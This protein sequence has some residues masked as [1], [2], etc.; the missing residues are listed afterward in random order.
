MNS[1]TRLGSTCGLFFLLGACASP[2]DE[3]SAS[4]ADAL[5]SIAPAAPLTPSASTTGYDYVVRHLPDLWA[6]LYIGRSATDYDFCGATAYFPDRTTCENGLRAAY[7]TCV[8]APAEQDFG[9]CIGRATGAAIGPNGQSVRRM[10]DASVPRLVD[11]MFGNAA[12]GSPRYGVTYCGGNGYC[13]DQVR[14]A[15][16]RCL[17]ERRA[18]GWFRCAG[19]VRFT[20]PRFAGNTASCA[21]SAFQPGF[22]NDRGTVQNKNNCYN[23]A[24]NRRTDTFAIP[25]RAAGVTYFWPNEFFAA[26]EADGLV[27]VGKNAS[28]PAPLSKVATFA[29]LTAFGLN[30]HWARQDRDGSWSGK[31][32][33]DP[34]VQYGADPEAA[35]AAAGDEVRYYC[36]CS[37]AIEGAGTTNVR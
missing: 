10:I 29:Q 18:D 13:A 19:R 3:P 32:S 1:L 7:K 34:A 15:Y 26:I 20:P 6:T 27:E 2:I 36:V 5:A 37:S 4:S 17:G 12:W 11:Y 31:N 8:R 28:C 16:A 33:N 23:Y 30:F 9:Q 25:G 21:A 22:W 14:V 35:N 24:V